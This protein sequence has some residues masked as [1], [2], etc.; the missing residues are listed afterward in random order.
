MAALLDTE[1]ENIWLALDG[2]VL[3][4]FIGLRL[5]PNDQMGEIHIIAVSP[6]HQRRGIGA[7]L[8]QFAD[9]QILAAGM[10]MVMV[11]TGGDSG[12]EPAR[13]A[14]ENAGFERWEVARYFKKL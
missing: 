7:A 14:Y 3:A 8:M 12:H 9:Q 13:L 2:D 10:T 1:P 5:N 4:G 6:D 11:E